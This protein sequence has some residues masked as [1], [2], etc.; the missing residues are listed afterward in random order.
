MSDNDYTERSVSPGDIKK[1][2]FS[3]GIFKLLKLNPTYIKKFPKVKKSDEV[4]GYITLNASKKTGL[5]PGTPV[6]VGAVAVEADAAN[7][8]VTP[9][10]LN[11]SLL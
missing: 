9:G 7:V 8:P 4:G 10:V 5:I 11:N 6:A 1:T 3:L 2:G